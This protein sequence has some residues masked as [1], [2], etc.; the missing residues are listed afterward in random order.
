MNWRDIPARTVDW[1]IVQRGNFRSVLWNLSRPLPD[2]YQNGGAWRD[3][4]LGQIADM[5]ERRWR[6]EPG[7]GDVTVLAIK[8]LI[9]RAAAGEDVTEC[10]VSGE[11]YTPQPWPRQP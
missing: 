10:A 8:E 9:D 4:T 7:V 1:S 2:Q 5:G 3:L 11:P 6:R